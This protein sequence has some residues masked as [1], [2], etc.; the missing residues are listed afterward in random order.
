VTTIAEARAH[1]QAE[2]YALLW[3]MWQAAERDPAQR[4]PTAQRD[5]LRTALINLMLLSGRDRGTL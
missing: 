4:L 3:Q 2:A 5:R 1:L